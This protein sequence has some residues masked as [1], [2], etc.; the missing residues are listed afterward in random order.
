MDVEHFCY[1]ADF[2]DFTDLCILNVLIIV[3]V[4]LCFMIF[5]NLWIL[6]MSF[7]YF[8]VTDCNAFC[9]F[10]NVLDFEHFCFCFFLHFI[11]FM[12]CYCFMKF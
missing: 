10:G 9:D 11:Y 7:I 2:H 8:Y 6:E 4:L 1:F 12:D 3:H 5:L